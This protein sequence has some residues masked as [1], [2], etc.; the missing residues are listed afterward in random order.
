ME[1][2]VKGRMTVPHSRRLGHIY[3]NGLAWGYASARNFPPRAVANRLVGYRAGATFRGG[4]NT[5]VS[6]AAS[7]R[8]HTAAGPALIAGRT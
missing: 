2:A 5:I 6:A 4:A 3:A 8:A 7:G 1:L